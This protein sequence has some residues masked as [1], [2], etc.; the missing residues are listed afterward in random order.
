MAYQTQSQKNVKRAGLSLFTDGKSYHTIEVDEYKKLLAEERRLFDEKNPDFHGYRSN[1][2]YWSVDCNVKRNDPILA[3]IVEELGD[4]ANG[5]HAKL[6][7]VEIPDD[8]EY[9]IDDYDGR[10]SIHEIHRSWS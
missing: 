7:V 8:V 5:E 10:E 4:A 6:N 1:N 2:Y 3:A 9:K